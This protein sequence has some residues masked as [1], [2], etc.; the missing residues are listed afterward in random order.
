MTDKVVTLKESLNALLEYIYPSLV[1]F[2]N[3]KALNAAESVINGKTQAD[4]QIDVFKKSGFKG[5]KK[6]LVDSVEYS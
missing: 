2:D 1:Y 6:Y 4:N 3:K 5:L